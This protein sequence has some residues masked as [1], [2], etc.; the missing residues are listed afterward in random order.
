MSNN[1]SS[2]PLVKNPRAGS[3]HWPKIISG[4]LSEGR[5]TSLWNLVQKSTKSRSMASTSSSTLASMPS[6]KAIALSRPSTLVGSSPGKSLALEL[7]RSMPPMPTEAT[8]LPRKSSQTLDPRA[9]KESGK[10]TTKPSE[11]PSPKKEAAGLKVH[12]AMRKM[13]ITFGRSGPEPKPMKSS[14]SSAAYTWPMP[15]RSERGSLRL[16]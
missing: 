1:I 8:A 5:K 7:I 14:G 10:R 12:S 11:K 6:M 13:P 2:L 16:R 4:P 3:S 9:E 15:G